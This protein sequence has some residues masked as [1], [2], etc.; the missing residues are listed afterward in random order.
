MPLPVA[1]IALHATHTVV[2]EVRCFHQSAALLF[3]VLA[4][5]LS[6]QPWSGPVE[7][8]GCGCD[9][10]GTVQHVRP[11]K[12]W[13]DVWAK[14]CRHSSSRF[15]SPAAAVAPAVGVCCTPGGGGAEKHQGYREYVSC[16]TEVYINTKYLEASDLFFDRTTK[17]AGT[18]SPRPL[19]AMLQ[20]RKFFITT[21]TRRQ[22][23]EIKQVPCRAVSDH[24]GGLR[25]QRFRTAPQWGPSRAQ[26]LPQRPERAS[27]QSI[28]SQQQQW[29]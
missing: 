7:R 26:G 6:C 27:S 22:T 9:V 12:L 23:A 24:L 5:R 2:G 16:V 3:C 4:G 19:Y 11:T 21:G 25:P 17:L 13:R 29:R 28:P 20:Q 8:Q 10:Q 14:K 1:A 18:T 15:L